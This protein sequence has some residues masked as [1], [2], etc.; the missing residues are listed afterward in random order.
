MALPVT[1]APG[2]IANLHIW[3]QNCW[4]VPVEVEITL[5]MPAH[6]PPVLSAI[7]AQ[8]DVLLEAAEVGE[9]IIPI[10]ASSQGAPGEYPIAVTIGVRYKERGLYIRSQKASGQFG[11]TLLA[12]TTGMSLAAVLGLGFVA[13]T[14][15]QQQ[16]RLHMEGPPHSGPPTDLTP[17]FVS[18]WTVADLPVQGKAQQYVNDQRLYLLPK[19]IRQPLYL[20]FMEESQTRF[21]NAALPLQI[22]EAI[23][24][25]KILTHTAEYFLNQTSRQD[26]ILVPAY[27]LAFRYDLPVSD[28]IPLIARADYGRMIRLAESV[29]FGLLRQSLGH[30]PWTLEEQLAITDL[31]VNQ[32]EQGG[33]LPAE[34]LYL[35][36]LLGGLL[37]ASQVQMPGENLSQSLSLLTKAYNQ[38]TT[39]LTD[40]PELMTIL[41]QL[42]RSAQARS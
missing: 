27:T 30:I 33:N 17:T 22:G 28:P 3:L 14:C 36:L 16:L 7:Q 11:D 24:L 26:A 9:V 19:L 40:N 34:F 21:R 38:R 6:P 12:F 18:H 25:A 29:S 8:T 37:V 15:P 41:E 4:D 35:P 10:V 39:D 13:R 31:V 2:Q 42:L 5:H 1:I 23:F 20:A 32:V